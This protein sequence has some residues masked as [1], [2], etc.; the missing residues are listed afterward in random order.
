M[1]L[2]DEEIIENHATNPEEVLQDSK[3]LLK[4]RFK[5]GYYFFFPADGWD[6]IKREFHESEPGDYDE[7]TRDAY[8]DNMITRLTS[9]IYL[10]NRSDQ[11]TPSLKTI[12]LN[13]LGWEKDKKKWRETINYATTIY[14][15]VKN[16]AW[17]MIWTSR[18][19]IATFTEY[20]PY[21]ISILCNF[22]EDYARGM[23]ELEN[24]PN[25]K[26]GYKAL[27]YLGYGCRRLFEA[28]CFAGMLVSTPDKAARNA[29]KLGHILAGDG[30]AGGILGA[31]FWFASLSLTAVCWFFLGKVLI[32]AITVT[33][34]GS[35]VAIG[36]ANAAPIVYS[37]LGT[38]YGA[39]GAAFGAGIT[40][41]GS[42]FQRWVIKPFRDWW[43]GIGY[44]L[45]V[46]DYVNLQDEIPQEAS[47][48]TSIQNTSARIF[49]SLSHSAS[50][51]AKILQSLNRSA[52]Q[53]VRYVINALSEP[54]SLTPSARAA[55]Q[56]TLTSINEG[57]L[58]MVEPFRRM[59]ENRNP[60]PPENSGH[61]ELIQS[62]IISPLIHESS[63]EN[64]SESSPV[65][66]STNTVINE[67]LQVYPIMSKALREMRDNRS[68]LPFAHSG[69]LSLKKDIF[70]IP[71]MDP[72]PS[73]T[74]SS[75]S[76]SL[77]SNK[78]E[79]C[80]NIIL[81][82][83]SN[84]AGNNNTLAKTDSKRPRFSLKLPLRTHDE[85]QSQAEALRQTSSLSN[86][87]AIA[88]SD[89]QNRLF[90]P[91]LP[92]IIH[93]EEESEAKALRQTPSLNNSNALATS[94]SQNRPLPGLELPGKV[95]QEEDIREK[96]EMESPREIEL[97]RTPSLRNYG[98]LSFDLYQEEDLY[99]KLRMETPRD[100]AIV[101]KDVFFERLRLG[102]PRNVAIL[103]EEP[104][105]VFSSQGKK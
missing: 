89:S 44:K 61:E 77:V 30:L 27:E 10:P 103:K 64:S 54:V 53:S 7:K 16:I 60:L 59:M 82:A 72:A 69:Y 9:Y 38:I 2:Y 92:V 14:S 83:N 26:N 55:I 37:A 85:E 46:S 8:L 1:G 29:D 71:P 81:K 102:T 49:Q 74:N 4:K 105:P 62:D 90:H 104:I 97:S 47:L 28:I 40:L 3:D 13:M 66:S 56:N 67:P 48:V 63:T 22:V 50:Q 96:L 80:E 5:S 84:T 6:P 88:K 39:V 76:S 73:K 19:I 51:S 11:G 91:E 93:H 79:N 100:L 23:S 32:P 86:S 24:D 94:D 70:E 43:Y 87:N 41:A 34:A 21:N 36:T 18:N 101:T 15:V 95:Y 65:I 31:V 78:P 99:E 98:R 17:S 68:P 52:S 42:V 35:A 12:G 33:L 20:L 57:F 58:G 25:K 75:E 45:P